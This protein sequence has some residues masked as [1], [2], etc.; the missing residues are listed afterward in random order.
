MT[1]EDV[2]VLQTARL[3]LWRPHADDRQGLL[4]L[5]TPEPVRRFL[6]NRPPSAADEYHRL[7]RNAG[8]WLLH[9]YGTFVCRQ[10]GALAIIGICGVFHSWREWGKGMDDVPEMGWI[11]APEVWGRG[12]ATEAAT[13]ALDW[14]DRFHGPRRI[15]CM[16]EQD[17]AASLAIAARLGFAPYDRHDTGEG[18]PLVLLERSPQAG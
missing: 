16:I 15:A 14:F 13:A 11:F 17:H 4:D 5:V 2:P 6:G 18:T 7:Q 8:S 9:G 12:Y 3:T 1:D 10:N